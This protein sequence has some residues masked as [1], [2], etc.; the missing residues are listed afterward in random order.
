[1][2]DF[3]IKT[4]EETTRAIEQSVFADRFS[5]MNGFLQGLDPRVKVVTFFALL[6]VTAWMKTLPLLIGIY[7]ITLIL[8]ILS[9]LPIVF[10]VKRVW[11]FIPIFTGV[12]ALPAIFNIV[13]PGTPLLVL[14]HFPHAYHFGPY[15]IPSSIAI[16][17]QG[18]RGG[19]ILV[20]RVAASVSIA[21]LLVL[22]TE[23]TRLLKSLSV[24]HV[25]E[26]VILVLAMTYRYIFLFLRVVE[27]MFLGRKSRLISDSDIKE[28]HNWLAARIGV[29]IGKSYNISNEV[30]LAMISRGWD[31]NPILMEDFNMRVRDWIWTFLVIVAIGMWL[32]FRR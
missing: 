5:S 1:M 16:T 26:M 7:I 29:L 22:T 20:M 21:I 30:H 18:L 24:L 9:R 8:A 28:Q 17:S 23:W 15:T 14:W 32:Y 6:I 27:G 11:I 13:T 12:I 25:P 31:G 3:V 4:L 19:A 2:A 10:F